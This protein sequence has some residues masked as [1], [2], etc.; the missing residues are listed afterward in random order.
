MPRAAIVWATPNRQ[1]INSGH[2]TF[3]RQT[4]MISVGSH[5][6]TTHVGYHVRPKYATECNGV[7][8]EP[9]HLR[10]RDLAW[11]PGMRGFVRDYILDATEA[12]GLWVNELFSYR[13]QERIVHGYI[14]TRFVDGEYRVVCVM[15]TTGRAKSQMILDAALPYLAD[16]HD[17]QPRFRPM[18]GG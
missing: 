9:G 18:R 3:D 14:L 12:Q 1:L 15:C 4:S 8:F 7:R 6:G 13:G 2:K 16:D 10:A 11:F 5:L 17:R